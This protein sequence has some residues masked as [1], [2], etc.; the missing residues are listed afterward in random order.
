VAQRESEQRAELSV[1]AGVV[2]TVPFFDTDIHDLAGLLR[3][4]EQ[5]W[6]T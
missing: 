3:L 1:G 2:A 6:S 5:L 4:G